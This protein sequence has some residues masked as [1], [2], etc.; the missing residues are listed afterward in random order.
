MMGSEGVMGNGRAGF[1]IPLDFEVN[2]DMG[3]G[4]FH[5]GPEETGGKYEES[6][7]IKIEGELRGRSL[8]TSH[9]G[10]LKQMLK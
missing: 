3:G 9:K 5:P 1:W 6:W 8:M 2:M 4:S 7:K 10:E